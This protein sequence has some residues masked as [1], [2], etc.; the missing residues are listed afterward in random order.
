MDTAR[1]ISGVGKLAASF[2]ACANRQSPNSTAISFPHFAASVSR[3]RRISASSMT[4][5]CTSVAR[6]TISMM[7]AAVTWESLILPSAFGAQKPPAPDANVCPGQS[8]RTRRRAPRSGS[9]SSTC[10]SRAPPPPKKVQPA[11]L[12]CFHEY[13]ASALELSEAGAE[14]HFG[15][16]RKHVGQL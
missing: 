4:S 2:N 9:N 1:Q 13:T 11:P 6:C 5:S 8:G 7:T 10:L 16:S 15:I 3:P 12:I 14:I